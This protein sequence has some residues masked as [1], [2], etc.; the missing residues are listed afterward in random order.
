MA[1]EPLQAIVFIH[2]FPMTHEVTSPLDPGE[3]LVPEAE[4]IPPRFQ[5]PTEIVQVQDGQIVRTTMDRTAKPRSWRELSGKLPRFTRIMLSYNATATLQATADE[6]ARILTNILETLHILPQN[7]G[8][9]AHSMGGLVYAALPS[10]LAGKFP[11]ALLLDTPT[12]GLN[13]QLIER[14]GARVTAAVN[15]MTLDPRTWWPVLTVGAYSTAVKGLW[16]AMQRAEDGPR[17]AFFA[18]LLDPNELAA[19]RDR[20]N[21]RQAINFIFQGE[22]AFVRSTIRRVQAAE[23]T[24]GDA[25]DSVFKHLWLHAIMPDDPKLCQEIARFVKRPGRVVDRRPAGGY[26]I[27][28]LDAVARPEAKLAIRDAEAFAAAARFEA[29]ACSGV[30]SALEA[31]ASEV[32]VVPARGVPDAAAAGKIVSVACALDAEGETDFARLYCLCSSCYNPQL[33]LGL[34]AEEAKTLKTM[35]PDLLHCF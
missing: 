16:L 21:E 13:I 27:Y 11:F 23:V 15:G 8:V 5:R 4:V 29:D 7:V 32:R 17:R 6:L 25:T 28:G 26:A 10:E 12:D 30:A 2:G 34:P 31:L 24:G 3:P 20:L 33:A 22:V 35:T 19:L 9:I 18:T 14:Y 1:T